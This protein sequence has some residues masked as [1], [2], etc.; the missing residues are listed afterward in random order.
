M[1][2]NNKKDAQ[3]LQELDLA[4]L[5]GLIIDDQSKEEF[6]S[7]LATVIAQTVKCFF[8]FRVEEGYK[9]LEDFLKKWLD[10]IWEKILN[11]VFSSPKFLELLKIYGVRKGYKYRR[12]VEITIYLPSGGQWRI[13][14]PYFVKSP[15]KKKVRRRG[16]REA[17]KARR[18]L[19]MASSLKDSAESKNCL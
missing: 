12:M 19:R 18:G 1:K 11:T 16:K 5:G 7:E 17:L 2:F 8:E 6:T 4:S 10:A 9:L 3:K 13:K 14:G 15:S